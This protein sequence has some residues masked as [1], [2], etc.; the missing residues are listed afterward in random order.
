VALYIW[1]D[2]NAPPPIGYAEGYY[3]SPFSCMREDHYPQK[4]TGVPRLQN[5]T[6]VTFLHRGRASLDQAHKGPEPHA[7]SLGN[8]L[9]VLIVVSFAFAGCLSHA[10]IV[11]ETATAGT[12][13]YSYV[14]EQ[15][16]LT[17]PGRKDALL[18]LEEKCP[19]GYRIAREGE[20]PRVDRA[21]DRAWMGQISRDGQVSRERRW[22]IQFVC[23]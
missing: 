14:E 12:V 6:T 4:D 7:P 16:V 3:L 2:Y 1:V 15:D 11:N 19:A 22:A 5:G 13:L 21:V 8:Q 10:Q 17:S 9:I 20:V 23:K 18:L